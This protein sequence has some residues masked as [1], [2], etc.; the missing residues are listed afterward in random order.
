MQSVR[1]VTKPFTGSSVPVGALSLIVVPLAVV[2]E[3]FMGLNVRS[4][5]IAMAI[6]ISGEARK[7]CV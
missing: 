7:A 5:L 1:S 4:P 6:T 3:P 2:Y